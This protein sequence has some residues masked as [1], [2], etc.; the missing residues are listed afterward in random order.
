MNEVHFKF[1]VLGPFSKPKCV[2]WF[3]GEFVRVDDLVVLFEF[4]ENRSVNA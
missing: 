1:S 4:L 2:Q 3:D